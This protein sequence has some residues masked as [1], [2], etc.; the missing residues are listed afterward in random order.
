MSRM[1]GTAENGRRDRAAGSLLGL[2]WGDA[3][4]CPV[5]GWTPA[6]IR[7]HY[8]SYDLLPD[9]YPASVAT[10][11]ASRRAGLRPLGIHS[12]DTQQALA[13]VAVVLGG[14]ST[15]RWAAWLVAGAEADAWRG[16]GPNFT[17]AVAALRAGVPPTA[18]GSPSAGIGAAMRSGPLGALL[19]DAPSTLRRVA[20]E[21]ATVTHADLRA[22]ATA[23]AVAHTVAELVAGVP[24][25]RVVEELAATVATAETSWRAAAGRWRITG[26]DDRRISSTLAAV[27]ARAPG[28]PTELA[29]AVA[30]VGR[31]QLAAH[32]RPHPNHGFAP[33]GGVHAILSGLLWDTAPDRVLADLVAAG[34]DTDTVAAICGSVLGAR[35]GASWIPVDRM[36][37]GDRLRRYA[38]AVAERTAPPEDLAGFLAAERRLTALERRFDPLHPGEPPG[39]G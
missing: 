35:Y 5:E 30:R 37:D 24:A 9:R 12:D 19:H 14:W 17:A 38:R 29:E 7:D 20:F 23:F 32:V 15:E 8:G 33:L 27:V 16:T 18:S 31:G 25:E 2:A 26:A 1:T 10:L 28:G 13:L 11:D 6:Q 3:F 21:S 34:G 22:S 36:L 4:G 39:E